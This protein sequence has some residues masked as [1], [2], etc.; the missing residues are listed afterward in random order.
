[1]KNDCP[2]DIKRFIR[3]WL[4]VAGIPSV[5]AGLGIAL[6]SA[7]IAE[8]FHLK[9]EEP[10][11]VVGLI[12]P[13]L[14]W[15]PILAGAAQGMQMFKWCS[16]STMTGAVARLAL[17]WFFIGVFYPAC[18]WAMLGHGLGICSSV[19]L[20]CIGLWWALHGRPVSQSALPSMRFCLF[21]SFGIL[22]AYAVLMT[23]DIVLVKHYL[24]DEIN[25]AYAATLGRM[26]VFL[27]GAI[28]VAM[29]P[30]VASSESGDQQ[31]KLFPRSL[32][33]SFIST[34]LV[35]GACFIV[36][37]LLFRILFDLEADDTMVA[38]LQLMCSMMVLA[39]ALNVTVQYGLAL[40][41]FR[42]LVPVVVTAVGYVSTV[43]VFHSSVYSITYAGVIF[44]LLGLGFSL[45]LLLRKKPPRSLQGGK[46]S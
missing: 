12:L 36:P 39:S 8:F 20:L 16:G 4:V 25:F 31:R 34:L 13:A 7:W 32:G 29:F 38:Y 21:Q 19:G 5:I 43:A 44:N 1:V 30:K 11:I 27:P 22:M 26:A 10:V 6:S 35:L 33:Y 40:H 3:K 14:C 18:G 37:K 15:L 2:G 42:E 28:V 24:P 23:A 46:N 45:W 41:R 17:G 9:R